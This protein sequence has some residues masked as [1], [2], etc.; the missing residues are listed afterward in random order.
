MDTE[1]E[2]VESR[3]RYTQLVWTPEFYERIVIVAGELSV[4]E[5]MRLAIEKAV[6]QVEAEAA[7]PVSTASKDGGY[8]D[9]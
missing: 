4:S 3:P 8:G 1:I 6:K 5:W 7:V 2:Q 9:R